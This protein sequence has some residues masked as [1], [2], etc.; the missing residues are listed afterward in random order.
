MKDFLKA[1]VKKEKRKRC[2]KEGK[3]FGETSLQG[4][5][6]FFC[7]V[8]IN[9]TKPDAGEREV[10]TPIKEGK[11]NPERETRQNVTWGGKARHL[12]HPMAGY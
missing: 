10:T 1:G 8:Q 12:Q 11:E 4:Q 5:F 2:H 6:F 3:N 9:P 7:F